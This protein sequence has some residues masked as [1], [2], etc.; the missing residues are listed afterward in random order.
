MTGRRGSLELQALRS[1][2]HRM[3]PHPPLGNHADPDHSV[4]SAQMR[5]MPSI[6]WRLKLVSTR[7]KKI[8][9]SDKVEVQSRMTTTS[10][11]QSSLAK[12]KRSYGEG[13]WKK[14]TQPLSSTMPQL[15]PLSPQDLIKATN[16]SQLWIGLETQLIRTCSINNQLVT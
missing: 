2:R 8:G 6:S 5:K 1:M 13:N 4:H 11:R 7:K 16:N 3:S 14:R 9:R 15:K 10:Q 12:K